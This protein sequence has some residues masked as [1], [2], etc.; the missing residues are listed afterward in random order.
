MT[1]GGFGQLLKQHRI[2]N[3][4]T[5]REFCRINRFDPGNYSRVERGLFAPPGEDQ[6]KRYARAL[7]IEVGS[8]EYVELLDQA[9]ADR[10]ELPRDLLSDEQVVGELPVL[11]RT[12]R[13]QPVDDE[14]L[15]KLVE[16]IRK[17]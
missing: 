4:Q 16:L 1:T 3:G 6:I 7:G 14:K 15:D 8:D 12:L 17:R 13:G 10:G 9:A 5:L 11:F 2:A